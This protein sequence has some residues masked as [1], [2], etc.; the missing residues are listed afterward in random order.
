MESEM[1]SLYCFLFSVEVVN[2]LPDRLPEHTM[3][4]GGC[5]GLY[6][7]FRADSE[8]STKIDV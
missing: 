2:V 4:P 6:F 1:K 7:S 5:L 3:I 8:N